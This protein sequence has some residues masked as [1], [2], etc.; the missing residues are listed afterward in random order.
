MKLFKAAI[1][2][3]VLAFLVDATMWHGHY[4]TH[5]GHRIHA[6]A[7]GITDGSWANPS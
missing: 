2:L 3:F 5:Y 7:T 1:A 4:R 6:I